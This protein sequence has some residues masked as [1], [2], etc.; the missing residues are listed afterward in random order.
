MCPHGLDGD[1]ARQHTLPHGQLDGGVPPNDDGTVAGIR[2]QG[3]RGIY[4]TDN[5]T[6]TDE[7]AVFWRTTP[8]DYTVS[9]IPQGEGER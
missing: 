5:K 4:H 8:E 2:Q 3:H 7:F 1:D 9:G 6:K